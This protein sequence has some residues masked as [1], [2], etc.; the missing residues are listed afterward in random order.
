MAHPFVDRYQEQA[1][2]ED[3]WASGRPELIVVHGRRR[4]GKSA[5]LTRF[6]SGRAIS[7]YVAAEQL[8]RDQLTDLGRVLGPMSVGFRRGRPPRLAIRDWEEAL[9]IVA[10]AAAT[11]RV[12]LVLD[13]FPYL[14]E[15]NRALPSLLQHWWDGVGSRSN[16]VVVL[17][18]S[19]QSMM[20]SLVSTEGALYGRP[21]RAHHLRP[22]DYYHAGRFASAWPPEDRV[23]L[24]AVAGGVPDY[25]EEFDARRPFR[26]ELL[27][28]A[29]S[30]GGRL[31]REAPNLLRSEFTEP[32][33]YET[34]LRGIANGYL[35]PGE[36]ATQAGLS[37]AN[38]VTPY[39]DRLIELG[40]V[41]RTVPPPEVGLPRSRNSQYVI[42]DP[43]LRFYFALVDPWRSA[44]ELGQG[45]AV[46]EELWGEE[47]DRFVSRTFEAVARQH[48][49]RLSGTGAIGPFTTVGFWWFNG[50]DIDA[51]AM[52][53][54]HLAAA[55]SAK[56][57]RE[58]VKPGDAADLRRDVGVVAPGD[59]PRLFLYSRSGFD[60]NIA[61]E[62]DVTPVTLRDLY[63]PDLEYE[64]TLA[65]RT[66]ASPRS[67]RVRR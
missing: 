18:G 67:G 55:G 21:T 20:R 5:L 46:L 60:R 48:L 10:A 4:V 44:I 63:A 66:P 62:P 40:F 42:A 51:A 30:P 36:I 64:R 27:R 35:T 38:R 56:W 37:G 13:E 6:A 14:V 52:A 50:G 29:Y 7:Y 32:R 57:T 25:L 47:F 15:A 23:R 26:D 19:Q 41:E 49:Q 61:A 39:L 22:F 12:G 28:V 34:V 45:A 59:R 1:D 17:A 31:F 16:V 9:S 24:Y 65:A 11:R 53:G 8:E 2:L 54:R 33:T 3:A 43:Y 58:R